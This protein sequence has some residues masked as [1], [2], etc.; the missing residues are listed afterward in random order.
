MIQDAPPQDAPPPEPP[1]PEPP[2]DAALA[3]LNA[4]L[5]GLPKGSLPPVETWHPAS[6]GTIDIRVGPDGTWFHDGEPIRRLPLVRLFS[7]ILRREPDG[8]FV[9][10]TPA[11]MLSIRVD[12]A[13]FVAV[14]MAVEGE[15]EGRRI[16]FRTNVDDLVPVDEAHALRFEDDATGG[17][18]PYVHVRRGLWALLTRPLAYDLLGLAEEREIDGALGFGVF[19]GGRFHRIGPAR[20]A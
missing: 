16:A 15:G 6:C 4:A 7:T 14:E 3:R 8:G 12:D 18:R 20:S 11:E 2:P 1:P 17:V 19:A 5:S 9:L 13:P 10:V